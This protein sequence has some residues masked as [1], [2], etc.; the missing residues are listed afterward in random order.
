MKLL[1][2]FCVGF[3][4]L[5]LLGAAGHT[6][7]VEV[8]KFGVFSD[9]H[10]YDLDLGT[11]GTAFEAYLA[12]DR[13]MLRESNAILDAAIDDLSAEDIDFV[14]VPG[15]LTKD[16][17]KTS[18]QQFAAK[19]AALEE[20]GIEVYVV[21]GNH[22]ILNPHAFRYD[23]DTTTPVDHV[24]PEE[25]ED[26]YGDFGYD[27]AIFSDPN[28]L[29]YV[30]E[31]APG[32]WLLAMDTCRYDNNIADDY[33]ETGGGYSA[34]TLAWVLEMLEIAKNNHKRVIGMQHH[35]LLEHYTGQ[36]A[37]LFEDYV[38]DDWMTVS[39][40]LAGAGLEI[41]FT[42]HF[43]AQ[44]ATS[45]TWAEGYGVTD[46]ETGS[47]A[48]FPVP[49]RVCSLSPG[50][51]LAGESKTIDQIAYDT[52]ALTFPEY[53]L[54]DTRS[55]LLDLVGYYLTL[56]LDQGGFGMDPTDPTVAFIAGMG[57]DAYIAHYAGDENPP[58]DVLQF[59]G[60]LLASADPMEQL[61][62]QL[63]GSLWTDITPQDLDLDQVLAEEG[64][65]FVLG[66]S[67]TGHLEGVSDT[68][69]FDVY[70]TEE[71]KI[72]IT[73]YAR[74]R[75]G[76]AP[77]VTV[78]GPDGLPVV[79]ITPTKK[80]GKDVIVVGEAGLYRFVVSGATADRTGE[81]LLKIKGKMNVPAYV[82]KKVRLDD[83][84]RVFPPLA[85]APFSIPV[86]TTVKVTAKGSGK[87]SDRLI[88]LVTPILPNGTYGEGGDKFEAVTHATGDY[89]LE[90]SADAGSPVFTGEFTLKM[91]CQWKKGKGTVLER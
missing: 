83:P 48:T 51:I 80:K 13:K 3:V 7:P 81:Y 17:E 21:P 57:A 85:E 52:G 6:G 14:L 86:G 68:D 60:G 33:P 30:A 23:G 39:K 73:V 29:S 38:V 49:Y 15:D 74:K 18:H 89:R 4:L 87:K 62:G 56:P 42:G 65:P 58:A 8:V 77:V 71:T 59:I 27:D 9:P 40:T 79:T 34:E 55:G 88:P 70:L 43:H 75:K 63:L 32:V 16:G 36:T 47:L 5:A 67:L 20:A 64:T 66:Q 90:V 78:L 26:I 61:L 72:K 50:G 76:L 91:K 44:D 69:A 22:D 82:A 84:T 53:A 10:F 24:T 45:A 46:I 54:E 25:F 1:T 31:P 28:S 37:F 41:V 19:I 12:Q 2:R 11:T 35:G